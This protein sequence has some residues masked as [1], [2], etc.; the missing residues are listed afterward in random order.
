MPDARP[1]MQGKP[2]LERL[3]HHIRLLHYSIRTEEAYVS[4][5]RR[6]IL[7]HFHQKCHPAQMNPEEIRRYL[8][9]SRFARR[10][11]RLDAES[12][13]FGHP[14]PL[15]RSAC[16]REGL[17]RR[18]RARQTC[19]SCAH[20]ADPRR[21]AS[22]ARTSPRHASPNGFPALRHRAEADGM[23]ASAHQGHGLRLHADYCER[24]QGQ[25]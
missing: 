17:C 24:R 25:A 20:G 21:G 5:V 14:L 19:G 11:R 1:A 8:S 12:S 22:P 18:G 10:D 7:F 15:Q 6:F 13:G 2:L 9:H 3:R 4:Y 23:R 16:R